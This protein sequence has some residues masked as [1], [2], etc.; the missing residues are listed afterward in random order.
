MTVRTRFAPSPTGNV[1]IG[2]I[3]AA[4]YNWLYARHEG[5]QFLLR[6]EDTDRERSTPEAV[7]AVLN[8]MNWLGLNFDETPVYQSTQLAA[9]LAAAEKLLAGGQAYKLDKGGAGK[10]ECIMFK[11]PGTDM[12]FHDE[13]KGDLRKAAKDLP[14]FVIVRSNGTPVFHLGNVVDDIDMNITH[15]IRGD[16]HVE[17]TF[18]HVAIFQALG[19]PIPKYAHLPMIVNA[20]GKPYSKRDGDAYVGEFR[21]KGYL[22][23][24]LFNYLVLL[25]WSPGDDREVLVRDELI[26]LFDFSRVQSSPAQMDMRKLQWMNGE[27]MKVL[28]STLRSEQCRAVLQTR[29][30][31]HDGISA[32]YFDQVLNVMGERIRLFTDVADQAGYFFTD[33][34]P[35]DEKSV[36]KRL[37]KEGASESLAAIRE[38]FA[39]LEVF[40]AESTDKAL[41]AVAEQK[42]I[43]PGE[44]VHPV[45]VAVSGTAAGPSLFPM[46]EVLGKNRVLARIDQTL[47]QF[48]A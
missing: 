35:Y 4:I 24:A 2:N 13:I 19:A 36:Q 6:I 11:M 15:I 46:L 38:A 18:R 3:R 40:T 8:S 30:L 12:A 31:W 37:K 22:P 34:Y 28:P 20:Q 5:G 25:G 23:E 42:G 39:G 48:F 41:H 27:Y 32:D 44:L 17:N 9:H 14:D 7:Q 33:N 1:H 43:H 10:G 26:R 21:E 47:K 16:D 29:G 45:R